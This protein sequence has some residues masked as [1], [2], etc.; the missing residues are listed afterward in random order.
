MSL[1]KPLKVG[2]LFIELIGLREFQM[3]VLRLRKMQHKWIGKICFR[4]RYSKTILWGV[5]FQ[6]FE[7]LTNL[8]L[9]SHTAKIYA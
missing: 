4:A 6:E 2:N 5:I 7:I 1:A 9:K 3:T 8:I